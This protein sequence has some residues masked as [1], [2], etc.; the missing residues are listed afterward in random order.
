MKRTA[1]LLLYMVSGLCALLAG[2]FGGSTEALY[3]PPNPPPHDPTVTLTDFSYTPATGVRAGDTITYTVTA[4]KTINFDAGQV[5]V[6]LGTQ[7]QP[8]AGVTS[9]T[10]FAWPKDDG[11]APDA[12]AGDG[13]FTAERQIPPF[14]KP[15]QGI[16]V[17]AEIDWFDDNPGQSIQGQPLDIGEPEAG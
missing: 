5:R 13:V 7:E 15:Q 9:R 4:S 10:L 6:Q 3:G 2:C 1:K 12:V 17:V 16:P 8:I 14:V 11:N